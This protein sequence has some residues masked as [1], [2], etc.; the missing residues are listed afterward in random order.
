MNATIS[1]LTQFSCPSCQ[2]KI[3]TLPQSSVFCPQCRKWIT[4]NDNNKLELSLLIAKP[5]Y[6]CER[7]R[8]GFKANSNRQKTCD[9]CQPKIKT[10]QAR[11]RK[12]KQRKNY[13]PCHAL[14]TV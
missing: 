11:L 6:I 13:S 7:C 3:E 1:N 4:D 10:I 5:R 12:Q 8:E 9:K 14:D 2:M